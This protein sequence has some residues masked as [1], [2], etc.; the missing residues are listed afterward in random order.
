MEVLHYGEHKVLKI[1]KMRTIE[2]KCIIIKNKYR[3]LLFEIHVDITTLTC[4]SISLY[5]FPYFLLFSTFQFI[6]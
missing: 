2:I 3:N 6:Y 4:F 1:I 5:Q